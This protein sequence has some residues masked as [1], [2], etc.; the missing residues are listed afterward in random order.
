M[1]VVNYAVFFLVFGFLTYSCVQPPDYPNAPEI[2]YLGVNQTSIGQGNL[3]SINDTLVVQ[4]AFTDGDGDLSGDSD[5]IDIFFT[6][7]RRGSLI[8]YRIPL[9]SNQGTGN[10]ISG[11]IT[12]RIPNKPFGICCAL[13]G[14][15]ACESLP[16][17]V[18]TFSYGIQIRDQANNYSNKVQTETITVLCN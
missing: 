6:D 16:G 9:I 3:N 17:M 8:P 2:T 5:S 10:G 14:F 7:S 4:F 11:E 12:V 1:K 13:E 18:D 15:S